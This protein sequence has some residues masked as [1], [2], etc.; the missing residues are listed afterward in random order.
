MAILLVIALM[1]SIIG[2]LNA[3]FEL[4]EFIT[5]SETINML[6]NNKQLTDYQNIGYWNSIME[7]NQWYNRAKVLKETYGCFS[8]Y[9]FIDFNSLEPIGLK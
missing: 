5:M 2:P 1:I 9:N 7:Y 3:K 6:A 8:A 4:K